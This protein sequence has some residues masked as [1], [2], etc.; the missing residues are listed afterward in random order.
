[1]RTLTARPIVLSLLFAA[2]MAA[3]NITVDTTSDAVA[4]DG[5]CSLRE[6]IAA[7]NGDVASNEC[8]AGTGTSDRILF[9]LTLPATITLGS[10]LPE[11]SESVAIV[12]PGIDDLTVDGVDLYRLF[13]F[14]NATDPDPWFVVSGLT[15]T[16]GLSD[17]DVQGGAIF[18][19]G[20]VVLRDCELSSSTSDEE[21]GA[22]FVSG[23]AT[24]ERCRIVDNSTTSPSGGGGIFV[25]VNS[26]LT[27]VDSTVAGNSAPEAQAGGIRGFNPLAITIRSSTISGNSCKTSGG[28]I[29]VGQTTDG[30]TTTFAIESSTI[31]LNQCGVG[32]P[33]DSA[34]GGGVRLV[35]GFGGEI[36]GTMVNSAVAENVDT[37]PIS[38]A[39]D[40]LL[41]SDLG[42]DF[43][44]LGFN[45]VGD[46]RGSSVDFPE[47]SPNVNGDFV[48]DGSPA[49]D[50]YLDVLADN[51]GPTPTH[52]FVSP[53]LKTPHPLFEQGSCPGAR[54]DQRGYG[55]APNGPRIIDPVG[56]L[57]NPEGD[58]CDIGA[59]EFGGDPLVPKAIFADGFESGR[60]LFW[61]S[62]VP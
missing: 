16:N 43:S 22:L 19:Q 35:T 58:G 62:D 46:N 40:L 11:I 60:F 27:L 21:G 34:C 10:D 45:L 31:T 26:S 36:L 15:L 5:F 20:T 13:K 30:D 57:N 23:E 56:I 47:G 25:Y 37:T 48:G 12:G 61:S 18:A 29:E 28:G 17:L 3:A 14:D 53:P 39:H 51:G 38:V 2:P 50:P 44:P 52:D 54:A 4:V 33:G 9:D 55:E 42:L 7:A 24:V 49:L 8:L 41:D 6:A 32:N 1:M 59:F